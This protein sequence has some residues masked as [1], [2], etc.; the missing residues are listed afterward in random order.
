MLIFGT[1]FAWNVV[2]I[3]KIMLKEALNW[4]TF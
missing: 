1:R 3:K 2:I 4:D